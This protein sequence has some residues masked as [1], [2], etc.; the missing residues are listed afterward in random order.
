[1]FVF[2]RSHSTSTFEQAMFLSWRPLVFHTC[3]A[4]FFPPLM[5]SFHST[6]AHCRIPFAL[7]FLLC[8]LRALVVVW[9]PWRCWQKTSRSHPCSRQAWCHPWGL[10]ALVPRFRGIETWLAMA[11]GTSTA[12][13]VDEASG[14]ISSGFSCFL[15]GD[16]RSMGSARF[17]LD[18]V[19]DLLKLR[20]SFV[21]VTRVE[22]VASCWMSSMILA[23]MGWCHC[24]CCSRMELDGSRM[25]LVDALALKDLPHESDAHFKF[26]E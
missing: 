16:D 9:C 17:A 25:E 11:S 15:C 24:V 19:T 3:S 18:S 10:R 23:Y 2:H 4:P 12:A 21:T 6:R 22:G 1:M 8:S 13:Y 26:L 20:I 5:Y 7:P 14:S